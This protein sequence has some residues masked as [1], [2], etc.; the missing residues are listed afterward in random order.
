MECL[1]FESYFILFMVLFGFIDYESS[2][3]NGMSKL[4]VVILMFIDEEYIY[5]KVLYIVCLC[6]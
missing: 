4:Y 3:D 6:F 1:R 2:W 5:R